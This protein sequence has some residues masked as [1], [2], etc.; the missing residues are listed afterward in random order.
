MMQKN[1]NN[2]KKNT[3]KNIDINQNLV[4]METE[5]AVLIAMPHNS[6]FNGYKFWH[7]RKL[8]R[9][10]RFDGKVSIGYTQDFVFRL[11]KYDNGICNSRGILDEIPLGANEIEI[12]F[13]KSANDTEPQEPEIYT[14]PHIEPEGA[15]ADESLIDYD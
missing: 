13:A 12:I 6:E 15:K 8:V 9:D 2:R 4:K 1:P 5:C 14:P 3:W 7:S 10:S 11:K